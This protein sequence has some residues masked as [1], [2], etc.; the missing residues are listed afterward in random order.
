MQPLGRRQVGVERLTKE[1]VGEAILRAT[2]LELLLQHGR[3]HRLREGGGY[4][5][6]R[7][8]GQG[9]HRRRL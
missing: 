8:S 1:R 3:S 6:G 9:V 5:L 7:L 4:Q 2:D